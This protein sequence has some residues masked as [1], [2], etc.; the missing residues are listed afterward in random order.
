MKRLLTVAAA[1]LLGTSSLYGLEFDY[2]SDRDAGLRSCDAHLYGGERVEA[3]RCYGALLTKSQDAR[4]RAEASWSLGD[5]RTANS[6]FQTAIEIYPDDAR[7]RTRWGRLYLATHQDS[8][9]VTLFQES[10][11][12]DPDLADAK[13]GLAS[14]SARRFEEEVRAPG[15]VPQTARALVAEVLAADPGKLDAYLLLARMDLEEGSLEVA[16]R[17][18]SAALDIAEA[19]G[20]PPLEVYALNAAID[21]LR[22]VTESPWTPR[23]LDYNPSFGEIYATPAHFSVI[24]RRYRQ[25]I[26]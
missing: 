14:V 2:S 18:L 7:A 10:L 8:E 5:L 11:E 24:T 26:A 4:I 12:L 22:G 21:L 1:S 9:A 3:E 6:Y 13:L 23:A 15:L 17:A 16:D 19:E 20:L 25:A